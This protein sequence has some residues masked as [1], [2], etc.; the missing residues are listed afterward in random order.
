MNKRIPGAT[1]R[2]QFNRDF[3]FAQA[4]EIADYLHD[5]GIT[6]CYGSPLFKACPQST[7]GYDVCDFN[8]LNPT[9]GTTEDFEQFVACLHELDMGL[10]LDM[11]PN[12]MS[13]SMSNR[14]WFD[15]LENGPASK[16]AKWF[17]VD[18]QWFEGKILLPV[19][20]DHFEA[21]LTAGKLRLV[22][23]GERF[24]IAYHD[25]RLPLSPISRATISKQVAERATDA[26][27]KD[28]NG[29]TGQAASFARLR[30]LLEQQHYRLA[31]WRTGSQ[32]INYRRFF[33]V[34]E[35]I[36]LRMELPEVFEETHRLLGDLLRRG[37][38]TGLRIDHPDGLWDPKEYLRKLDE[39]FGD[40]YVVV[41]KILT[42]DEVLPDDWRADGTTGYDFLNRLNGIFV[43]QANRAEFDR[44]YSQFIGC[45]HN[46]REMVYEAKKR[47][48]EASFPSELNALTRRL[49]EIASRSQPE[50]RYDSGE[51]REALVEVLACFPV[52]RTY[53][54]EE[55]IEL[56]AV[57]KGHIEHAVRNAGARL[58]KRTT[59]SMC[60]PVAAGRS[61]SSSEE[62]A[63]DPL[64]LIE[65]LLRLRA[66][67]GLDE[68]A[69]HRCREFVMSFQQL[70]GPLMA[71]GLEDTTFY[72]FN[73]LISLNEV[74]GNPDS[75]GNSV[76]AFYQHNLQKAARW[77]H[78]L[79]ATATHDTKR[80]EDVR[81][82]LNVLSEIPDDWQAALQRWG[83][84]NAGKK[85]TVEGQ[86]APDSNDEYL[87][88]QTLIGA[89][90]PEAEWRSFRERVTAC[91]LKS[92]KEAKAHTSW[93]QPNSAYE[94]ATR[95]FI[96]QTLADSPT[97]V[98]LADLKTF[99]HRVAFFGRLNS[100]SQTLLKMTAPGVPDF[101]QGSELWDFNLVDPDNRRPVDYE[102]RRRSLVELKARAAQNETFQAQFLAGLL[103]D[104]QIGRSKLYLIWRI[105]EFRNR[106]RAVFDD[107]AY[108][109]L[110]AEGGKK[111]HVCA[112]AR[113]WKNEV[114]IAIV[115]RLIADLAQGDSRSSLG[116]EIWEDTALV[117]SD[118]P[119]EDRFLN[120]LTNETLEIPQRLPKKI[121]VRSLLAKFPVALI[122]TG[123]SN[124][125]GKNSLTSTTKNE[126]NREQ[127]SLRL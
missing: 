20:E 107:G 17:D 31:F 115:P 66:P 55:T 78:S 12:H 99:Q 89:L 111:E 70:S 74:G 28:F 33:D 56:S 51:L 54:T 59:R 116:P 87:F 4:R 40:V 104:D 46:F 64:C 53:V 124:S 9:L 29:I 26:T 25:H 93:T 97:N 2:L 83:K 91:I 123:V 85:T 68:S 102:I 101:Y 27:L 96:E 37:E 108:V 57:E 49:E 72:N 63:P 114:A 14:W 125:S 19:L 32:E 23:E 76:D 73:R 126:S 6:D 71:K 41:E 121:A 42:D 58:S 98:F 75:F 67:D 62:A 105:L 80:G 52:Y 34:N 16:Y 60:V 100:L 120:V 10:L 13:T 94:D 11:V 103:H 122:V 65:G 77:P 79:L 3:T 47:I 106:H 48:L 112:F 30:D 95:N 21:V 7:H 1:Y 45:E 24:F 5:L 22:F 61:L 35:L 118:L 50:Q 81:A 88:Y 84:L 15:V 109:P 117:L 69:K 36:S 110:K 18:W 127:T 39:K 43:N 44:I 8:Q 92:I 90:P 119:V 38:V 82:C 113:V 86:P